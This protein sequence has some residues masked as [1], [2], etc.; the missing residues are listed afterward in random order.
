MGLV[1]VCAPEGSWIVA[2][3]IE[4]IMDRVMPYCL[5][6]PCEPDAI[7][8]LTPWHLIGYF[9]FLLL[10]YVHGGDMLWQSCYQVDT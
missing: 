8:E 7:G 1:C 2:H 3:D 6:S 4:E 10:L 5:L 9:Y